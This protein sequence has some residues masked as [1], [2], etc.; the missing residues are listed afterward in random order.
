[1]NALRP[2]IQ[3]IQDRIGKWVEA[4]FAALLA[5]C[6]AVSV[7]DAVNLLRAPVQLDYEEGNIL[8][9]GL[10]IVHGLTPYPDPH[11]WPLVFNPYGPLAYLATAALVKLFG[12]GFTAPRLLIVLLAVAVAGL[13]AAL[14]R[15]FGSSWPVAIGFASLFLCAPVVREWM[16]FLRVDL[17]GLALALA[18]LCVF[19][20]APRHWYLA[21]V[22]FAAALFVKYSLL[23]A[24]AACALYLIGKRDWKRLLQAAGTGAALLLGGFAAAQLWSAGHFAFHMFGTH[25][26]P[27]Q[28]SLYIENLIQ[29]FW[30][31][32][33]LWGL[34]ALAVIHAAWRRE[35]A[36]HAL[37]FLMALCGAVTVGKLGSNSNHLIEL[38]AAICLCAGLGW[39][40]FA[41]WVQAKGARAVSSLLLAGVAAAALLSFSF[42]FR[43]VDAAGCEQAYAFLRSH[44]D[45]VLSENVGALLLSGKPVQLSNPYVY[46]QLVARAGWPD[47]P[48]RERLRS[49]QFDVVVLQDQE[50]GPFAPSDR[51]TP[52]IL[53]EIQ[54]NYRQAGEFGCPEAEL[55]FVH[56]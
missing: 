31:I 26:D 11:G 5:S 27:F 8:N 23:A 42:E 22:F 17:M 7:A 19:F 10:R 48:V 13:L 16:A 32:P 41:G 45:R 6:A 15:H 30:E 35:M 18:G 33:A 34:A 53:A 46:A 39:N 56:K 25:P 43:T 36:P 44:G 9:A 29:L 40:R 37:Y 47:G 52:G 24:P 50:D 1:M 54:A 12:V 51:W 38:I 55:A 14:L 4:A 2:R 28:F 20:L 21:V 3:M 49:G